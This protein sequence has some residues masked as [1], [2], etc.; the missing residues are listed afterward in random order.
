MEDKSKKRKL[1]FALKIL[2]IFALFS[3]IGYGGYA[4]Y[5]THNELQAVK[6]RSATEKTRSEAK[7]SMLEKNIAAME[8]ELGR[9]DAENTDLSQTLMSE[10]DKNT[11]FESQ[12]QA[13]G[14]TVG[15]LTK[16]SQTDKELL[17]KYSKVYFLNEHYVPENL[18]VIDPKYVFEKNKTAQF[19]AKAYPYLVQMLEA[20]TS[21]NPIQIISAYR[22][23]GDQTLLKANYVVTY[24]SGANKFSADQG[25][26]EH[27]LGTTMDLTTPTLGLAFIKFDGSDAYNWLTENAYRYGFILSYPKQNTYFQYEPW[28][29]RFVG[30]DLAAKLHNNGQFFYDLPAREIDSY[31][32]SIF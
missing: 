5:Q 18:T 20:A 11:L 17:Q 13:I 21:T 31:L 9:K 1:F 8:T 28:H 4:F 12:I 22:S 25:Y 30:V 15:K 7:I 29:W 24:G 23:F 10:K 19:H 14:G 3:A 27:Q 2:A 6:Q 32:I 16:L 26:S